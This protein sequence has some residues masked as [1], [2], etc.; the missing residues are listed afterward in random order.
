MGDDK[1]LKRIIQH[2]VSS[3]RYWLD[4]PDVLFHRATIDIRHLRLAGLPHV[5]G[6]RPIAIAA[7][8]LCGVASDLAVN[9]VVSCTM[10]GSDAAPA[11]VAIATCCHQLCVARACMNDRRGCEALHCVP[12]DLFHTCPCAHT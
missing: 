8:H 5:H 11:G 7:K 9:A 3:C 2:S 6:D 4:L 1:F 10:D 12:F